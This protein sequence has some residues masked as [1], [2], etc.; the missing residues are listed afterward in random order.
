MTKQEI[1][2]YQTEQINKLEQLVEELRAKC[3]INIYLVKKM[4]R[5]ENC[6]YIGADMYERRIC[7]LDI[8]KGSWVKTCHNYDKWEVQE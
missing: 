7:Q 5:C 8:H 4:K 1:I 3:E 6:K 2:D